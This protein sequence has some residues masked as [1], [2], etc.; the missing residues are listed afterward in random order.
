[1][2]SQVSN[3]TNGRDPGPRT[4]VW[5]QV[6]GGCLTIHVEGRF[7]FDCHTEFRRA[8]EVTTEKFTECVVD[9]KATEY[10]D[11]AALGMLLVLR[12][13]L[14]EGKVR[15]ANCQPGVLNIL[16]I[17]NFAMLFAID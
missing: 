5:A 4:R 16:K 11:S 12:E 2:T 9:L 3:R 14:G 6:L 8:Y 10:L 17:A 15:I 1:M 7:Q 13:I